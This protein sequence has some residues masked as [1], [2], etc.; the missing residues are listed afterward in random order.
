MADGVAIE[1]HIATGSCKDGVVAANAAVFA[2]I[3][4][5]ATLSED[6]VAWYHILAC[7]FFCS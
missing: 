2:R 7:G 4:F 3:P 5:G 1:T 6:Y